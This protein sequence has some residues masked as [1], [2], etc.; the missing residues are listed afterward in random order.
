MKMKVC[1]SCKV[2]KPVNQFYPSRDKYDGYCKPCRRIRDKARNVRYS[3]PAKK[4]AQRNSKLKSLYGI[5]SQEYEAM[6][7]LQ[8]GVCAICLSK[9]TRIIRGKI[10]PLVV[11]HDHHTGKVRSLLCHSCNVRL[12]VIEDEQ[13]MLLSRYYL[14]RHGQSFICDSTPEE[15][16][17]LIEVLE[18]KNSF[19]PGQEETKTPSREYIEA[20]RAAQ[21]WIAENHP[22]ERTLL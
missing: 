19:R 17:G 18:W 1:G 12:S 8:N 6:L 14:R 9:E 16:N 22:P 20:A 4:A 15:I 21:D 11:D 3:D 5:T 13:F 2:E 10:A 7:D